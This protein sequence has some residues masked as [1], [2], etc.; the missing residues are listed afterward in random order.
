[1]KPARIEARMSPR[2]AWR[3]RL[4]RNRYDQVGDP[5]AALGWSPGL[6]AGQTNRHRRQPSA[7]SGKPSAIHRSAISH[8]PA[9]SH[10]VS[11]PDSSIST[12]SPASRATCCS[13]RSLD[14]GLAAR[15]AE[16]RARQS[17]GLGLRDRGRAGAAR[18]RFGDEVRRARARQVRHDS[19]SLT[20]PA[21]G[22]IVTL[23]TTHSHAC[24]MATVTIIPTSHEHP[25]R[26][27]HHAAHTLTRL[28]RA[29]LTDQ[30]HFLASA[31]PHC[32]TSTFTTIPMPTAACRRSS[33]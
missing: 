1:M 8:W 2:I 25:T 30:L 16:R 23:I 4:R 29:H 15:R 13:A 11:C 17:R 27:D 32:R 7:I 20:R 6:A 24:I 21:P 31:H 26:R 18:G 28:R 14:A 9:I 5:L 33:R 3:R 12:V 10:P 19:P 22:T